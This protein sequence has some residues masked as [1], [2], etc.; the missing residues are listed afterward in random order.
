MK[1]KGL[2]AESKVKGYTANRFSPYFCLHAA[3]L[4]Y[5][6]SLLPFTFSLEAT[7][8]TGRT[9]I[10]VEDQWKVYETLC[11]S[12][13]PHHYHGIPT[14]CCTSYY[15]KIAFSGT[16]LSPIFTSPSHV[17]PDLTPSC[18]QRHLPVPGSR[19]V[20]VKPS[21]LPAAYHRGS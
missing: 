20:S 19:L 10:K 16:L 15:E 14:P 3:N 2:E 21:K 5:T 6:Q 12:P 8:K 7:A 13:C 17:C 9:R 18:P 1:S 4:T 11:P